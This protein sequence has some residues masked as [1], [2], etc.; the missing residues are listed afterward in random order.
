MPS[1]RG[2]QS[3]G[4]ER[5]WLGCRVRLGGLP[6]FPGEEGW[7]FPLILKALRTWEGFEM[8]S[9]IRFNAS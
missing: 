8:E 6:G 2:Q 7:H 4:L 1:D 9:M 3:K 5:A